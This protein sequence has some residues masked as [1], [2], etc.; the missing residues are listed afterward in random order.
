MI[1]R[2]VRLVLLSALVFAVASCDGGGTGSPSDEQRT[3]AASEAD[4]SSDPMQPAPDESDD[5]AVVSVPARSFEAL[6]TGSLDPVSI[7]PSVGLPS[8]EPVRWGDLLIVGTADGTV[9]AR[10]TDADGL[11]SASPS[12]ETRYAAPID[13]IAVGPSLLLVAAGSLVEAISPVSGASVWRADLDGSRV[14]TRM[15]MTPGSVYLGRAD[16]EVAAIAIEDGTVRWRVRLDAPVVDRIPVADGV[17]YAATEDGALY[18]I[19]ADSGEL[20]WS[21]RA[22][23]GLAAGPS[24]GSG[25]I[26]LATI[27]GDV[28]VFGVD[29]S[30]SEWQIDAGPVLVAPTWYDGSLVVV[31]GA[32]TVFL[33]SDS[34]EIQ[35]RYELTA[36]LAGVPV[37]IGHALVLGEAGGGLVSVDL[38]SGAEISRISFGAP[39]KGEAALFAESLW[40]VLGDGSIRQVGFDAEYR[41]A[42]LLTAEG[43]WV[44]PETGTFRLEDERVSLAMRSGRDAVFEITVTSA[45]SEDLVLRV[46]SADGT[47]VATNMGKVALSRTVRAA[48]DAGLS[49][50]LRI[51][52]PS[53]RGEITVSVQTRQLQ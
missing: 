27:E 41:E 34:G 48:L 12:W 11:V 3:D 8:A 50:E 4:T 51:S 1:V 32:G 23:A 10:S 19:S 29:G 15:T 33:V 43:S 18:A 13:A 17:A 39:L 21:H 24:V 9:A 7:I 44:L 52:R 28:F 45:P 42:P 35:W 49:Y 37:R 46:V 38:R 36:H 31:D 26:A 53:P 30:L 16:G 6:V 20:L 40:W 47:E 14:T 22:S 5:G 25:M 2:L